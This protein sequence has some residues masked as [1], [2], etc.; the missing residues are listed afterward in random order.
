MK[1]TL[2]LFISAILLLAIV[3]GNVVAI[4]NPQKLTSGTAKTQQANVV[5]LKSLSFNSSNYAFTKVNQTQQV[6]VTATYSNQTKKDVTNSVKYTV[7]N[8]LVA[9]ISSSGLIKSKSNGTT[10][11]TAS[12]NGVVATT[13]ITVNTTA[14]P[15]KTLVSLTIVPSSLDLTTNQSKTLVVQA[16]Y[17]DQSVVNV[18]SQSVF[19]SSNQN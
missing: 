19:S 3:I 11:L 17:S 4:K 1:K 6:K 7:S 16:N 8:K 2:F 9:S 10:T 18:T 12:L 14:P 13:T 5:S 15:I